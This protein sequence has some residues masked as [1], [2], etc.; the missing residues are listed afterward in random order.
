M[1]RILRIPLSLGLVLALSVLAP[2]IPTAAHAAPNSY[3]ETQ[4]ANGGTVSGRVYFEND[5]P[6]AETVQPDR[7]ADTCGVRVPKEQFVVDE[8]SKGLANAVIRI[9]GISSGK[10][11][12]EATQQIEQLKCRYQPHIAIVRPGEE[13]NIV[14]QDPILHNIHAY[15]GDE[16]AFNLAQPFQG[17]ASPQTLEEEGVV[18]VACDVH[19]WMEAWVLVIDSPYFAVTDSSGAFSISGVPP[20][21]Y[22]ITMWHEVL[23]SGEKTVT[24]TSGGESQVEFV[25]GG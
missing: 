18:R 20:G 12:S 10:P 25:I 21:T 13:F 19:N 6:P 5:F 11:F 8:T 24:V 17:Q 3:S 7:D 16:T 1:S 4:V 2:G 15:R 14:N 9:E 23:G 22:S